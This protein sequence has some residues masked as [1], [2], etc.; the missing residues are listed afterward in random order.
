MLSPDATVHPAI[1]L[2]SRQLSSVHPDTGIFATSLI[3]TQAILHDDMQI[4]TAETGGSFIMAPKMCSGLPLMVACGILNVCRLAVS[5][6]DDRSVKV[7]DLASKKIIRSYDDHSGLVNTVAFHPDGTCVASAGTDN[8][9]K[10]W[11]VRSV[12]GIIA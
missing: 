3:N 1:V 8:T 11:D 10:I 12:R 6:G 5:G 4:A 9:I 2:A 7:W